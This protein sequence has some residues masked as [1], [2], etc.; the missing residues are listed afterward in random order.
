MPPGAQIRASQWVSGVQRV[1]APRPAQVLGHGGARAGFSFA[2]EQ[3]ALL[4]KTISAKQRAEPRNEAFRGW[5]GENQPAPGV[6][7]SVG[8]A[9]ATRDE[10]TLAKLDEKRKQYRFAEPTDDMPPHIASPLP[11]SEYRADRIESQLRKTAVLAFFADVVQLIVLHQKKH[12]ATAWIIWG[13][14]TATL[15]SDCCGWSS[16]G[17]G[18]F[19]VVLV[20]MLWF[21]RWGAY[22]VT[23]GSLRK[24]SGQHLLPLA[25]GCVACF[26]ASYHSMSAALAATTIFILAEMTASD[27]LGLITSYSDY[28]DLYALWM[29]DPAAC[30]SEWPSQKVARVGLMA[31]DSVKHRMYP[32]ARS[33]SPSPGP[34][35][36]PRRCMQPQAW[37]DDGFF[38]QQRVA[39][40][41]PMVL[42]RVQH[43]EELSRGYYESDAVG[44]VLT[45]A[46]P[47]L[48]ARIR[49]HG[50]K[51]SSRS[52]IK[53]NEAAD[54]Q[55]RLRFNAQLLE[56]V[57][58]D[59]R[60]FECDF[61][62]YLCGSPPMVETQNITSAMELAAGRYMLVPHALFVTDEATG[63]LKAV[64]IRVWL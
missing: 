64:G 52:T 42:R 26:C 55:Q 39:G 21:L 48:V 34:T 47:S 53:A 18:L 15:R 61:A 45:R 2:T 51:C 23:G 32:E 17:A 25:V 62:A 13:G 22:Y 49:S 16:L 46:V 33:R 14:L 58:E 30:G 19:S 57:L 31:V 12:F 3:H 27:K 40:L 8:C 11:R 63:V 4:A 5:L 7:L 35:A 6:E 56:A 28:E 41:N 43:R 24:P 1:D 54:R 9:T 50:G 37:Q 36:E 29:R 20:A 10:A 60:L 38:A 44:L 59:G